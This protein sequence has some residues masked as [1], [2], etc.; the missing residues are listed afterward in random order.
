VAKSRTL[1]AFQDPPRRDFLEANR[2]AWLL[3]TLFERGRSSS[4]VRHPV[5]IVLIFVP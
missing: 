5:G 4:R 1:D 2:L 3:V